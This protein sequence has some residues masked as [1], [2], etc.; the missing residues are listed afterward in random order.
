MGIVRS[1]ERREPEAEKFFQQ[2]ILR[3]PD[4]ASAHVHLGL[5]YVQVGR[6][7]D[8]I[9][10]LREGLRIDPTRTDASAALVY[11]LRDDAWVAATAGDS[12]R[13]LALLIDAQKL[14]PDNPYVHFSFGMLAFT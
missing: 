2:A 7:A 9:P 8:A 14:A 6:R 11:V 4:F 13:A 10:Q 1:Q 3:N 12:E 5:L